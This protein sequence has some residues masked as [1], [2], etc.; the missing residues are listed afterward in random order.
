MGG[1]MWSMG[2][3]TN[4]RYN[5]TISANARNLFNQVNLSSP[6]GNLSSPLFGQSTSISGMFG[7]ASA[8]NRKIDLQVRFT[9]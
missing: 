1:G 5:V 7:P 4:R 3:G 8:A 2:A 6:V 9:F